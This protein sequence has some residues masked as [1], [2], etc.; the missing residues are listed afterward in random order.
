MGEVEI[1][2]ASALETTRRSEGDFAAALRA[3]EGEAPLTVCD[4][5]KRGVG[6]QSGSAA[7][8]EER[9]FELMRLRD[10]MRRGSRGEM[11]RVWMFAGAKKVEL[12]FSVPAS[13]TK[14]VSTPL[15]PSSSFSRCCRGNDDSFEESVSPRSSS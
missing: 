4:R 9:D 2:R 3:I 5:S 8:D 11:D 14:L 13:A 7:S 10:A 12:F 6:R 1:G 15:A